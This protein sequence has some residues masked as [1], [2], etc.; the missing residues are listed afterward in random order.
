MT[1]WSSQ[2]QQEI[3]LQL[4]GRQNPWD[5][6]GLCDP[7]GYS[8]STSSCLLPQDSHGPDG[9]WTRTWKHTSPWNA[10]THKKCII[11]K[12]R[13]SD[14]NWHQN[15][16]ENWNLTF[17]V[18]MTKKNKYNIY[19]LLYTSVHQTFCNYSVQLQQ[20][21]QGYE[22]LASMDEMAQFLH[23]LLTRIISFF[24]LV[25]TFHLSF[26]YISLVTY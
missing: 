8:C 9:R 6:P 12:D 19:T 21:L 18:T 16:I 3:M 7:S 15:P 23:F 22:D 5:S 2:T 14:D 17:L 26:S 4:P 20:L 13:T 11:C 1:S 10:R 24:A 25:W